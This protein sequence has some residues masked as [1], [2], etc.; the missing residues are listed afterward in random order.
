MVFREMRRKDREIDSQE[1][2]KLLERGEYGVLSM[3]CENGY[4]YGVPLN[5][6]YCEGK[7]YFHCAHEGLKLDNIKLNNKVSFC[8]VGDIRPLPEK[9]SY[10]YESAVA[11]GKA[12]TVAGREKE[13]ALLL[14]I[15]KYSPEFIEK[16]KEYINKSSEGT[17]VVK[18]NIEHVTG[19]A[20]K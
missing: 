16:G 17:T 18:L 14:L 4:A 9:F 12:E 7:I 1:A 19:K 6:A 15:R 2:L 5:Y 20:R 13:E 10:S 11:F 8:V 3:T